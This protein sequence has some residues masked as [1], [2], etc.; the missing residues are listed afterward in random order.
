MLKSISSCAAH[1][2]SF[3]G[4]RTSCFLVNSQSRGSYR[5]LQARLSTR[6]GQTG[7][8][9]LWTSS[10]GYLSGISGRLGGIPDCS[11][12]SGII[13]LFLLNIR[14]IGGILTIFLSFWLGRRSFLLI[15]EVYL[16]RKEVSD[17]GWAL[18]SEV[19][20]ICTLS[21]P[22]VRLSRAKNVLS[23]FISKNYIH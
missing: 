21:R 11:S 16:H 10:A 13:L 22:S 18:N 20:F 5:L 12:A 1:R 8:T 3:E 9:E 23:A 15:P 7:S 2:T 4:S 17:I 6:D 14:V 19:T